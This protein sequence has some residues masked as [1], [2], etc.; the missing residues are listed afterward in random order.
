MEY[1]IMK[2][3]NEEKKKCSDV[4]HGFNKFDSKTRVI[5]II[6]LVFEVLAILQ[7]IITYVLIPKTF[8]FLIGV[9]IAFAL[10]IT[11][12]VVDSAFEK[13]SLEK[14]TRTHIKKIEIL[15]TMLTKEYSVNSR[16]KVDE[17]INLYQKFVNKKEK[18]ESLRNKLIYYIIA[19]FAGLLSVSFANLE[20]IGINF[21]TW[22][23]LAMFLLLLVVL[24]SLWI[25]CY[26]YFSLLKFDYEMMIQDLEDLKFYKY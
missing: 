7:I 10:I 3:Y 24:V 8:W 19:A 11:I 17:L 6:L 16:E 14:H 12:C 9:I 26:K 23:V 25:Y 15:D 13:K 21:L 20:I 18:E 22:V 5:M 4:K 2:K 1:Y